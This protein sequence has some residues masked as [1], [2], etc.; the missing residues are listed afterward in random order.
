[1]LPE[2]E[3]GNGS[4]QLFIGDG[5]S[6]GLDDKTENVL[7]R[8]DRNST[9]HATRPCG[10]SPTNFGVR[11]SA[12]EKIAGDTLQK[13]IWIFNLVGMMRPENRGEGK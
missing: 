13:R 3:R 6:T 9:A 10:S 11:R 5:E 12:N 7:S 2:R 8:C 4:S 1:M